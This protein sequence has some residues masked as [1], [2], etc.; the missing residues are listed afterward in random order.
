MSKMYDLLVE[1][2]KQLETENLKYEDKQVANLMKEIAPKFVEQTG[3]MIGMRK[4]QSL[5]GKTSG[6]RKKAKKKVT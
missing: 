2:E 6:L 4:G 3:M 5:S 1:L